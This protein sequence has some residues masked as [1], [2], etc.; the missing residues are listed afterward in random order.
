MNW[1][2]WVIPPAVSSWAASRSHAVTRLDDSVGD[3]KCAEEMSSGY[4]SALI[5]NQVLTATR[6]VLRGEVAFERDGVSFISPEYR[7]PV[8]TGLL[9]VAARTGELRVLDFGGSLGSVFWQHRELLTGLDL[10]W[11]VVEQSGFVSAGQQLEQDSIVFFDR[12][13][14]CVSSQSPNVLLLSSV[15]QYLSDPTSTLAQLLTPEIDT[16]IIDRTPMSDSAQNT[17]TLQVVP[18]H[19]Y[20]G[21]YPAWIFSRT[22]L[23]EQLVG[24][25]VVTEFPG[26]EPTGRTTSGLNFDWNG[27]IAQ[28]NSS[29]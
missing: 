14:S 7:W 2:S 10:T 22:W 27:L 28:R 11:S 29:D 15:L 6:E 23:Y 18:E 25:T 24:F 1:R 5:V 12:I 13:D 4:D 16:V 8:L 17:A 26:I 19:I 3:W 20:S 21:S 9:N